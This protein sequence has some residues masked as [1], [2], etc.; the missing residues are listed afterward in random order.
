MLDAFSPSE[1]SSALRLKSIGGDAWI[2]VG[3]YGRRIVR[4]LA[5]RQFSPN[6]NN[7]SQRTDPPMG[8]IEQEALFLLGNRRD[9]IVLRHLRLHLLRCGG[10]VNCAELRLVMM[11]SRPRSPSWRGAKYPRQPRLPC[12]VFAGRYRHHQTDWSCDSDVKALPAFLIVII[13]GASDSHHQS[14]SRWEEGSPPQGP[15]PLRNSHA[16]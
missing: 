7:P 14:D 3:R 5:H 11:Q 2:A 12:A 16:S 6:A 13:A 1:L 9:A 8:N 15:E 10:M 4:T